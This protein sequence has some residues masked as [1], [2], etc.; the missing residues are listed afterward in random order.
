MVPTQ[1]EGD[2][3]LDAII[4]GGASNQIEGSFI[5]LDVNIGDTVYFPPGAA[6]EIRLDDKVMYVVSYLA[7]KLFIKKKI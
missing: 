7:I 5:S 6:D 2:S 1:R 4:Q 3:E